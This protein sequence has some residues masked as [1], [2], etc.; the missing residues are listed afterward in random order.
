MTDKIVRYAICVYYDS[1]GELRPFMEHFLLS[2]KE[3]CTGIL[4]VINGTITEN[5]KIKISNLGI[6]ILQREN[7]GYDFHAYRDGYLFLKNTHQLI[8]DELIFCNSSCYGPVTPIQNVFEVMNRKNVDFWGLTQWHSPPWPDHIQSYFL[9]FRKSI[10]RSLDFEKYWQHLPTL[11]NRKE[12]I[13]KCEVSLTS[14][15][16]QK[17]Y[18]WETF[19]KPLKPDYSMTF[20]YEGL[21]DGLPLVKRKFF[22]LNKD[23]VEKKNVISFLMNKTEYDTRLIYE[24]FFFVSFLSEAENNRISIKDYIKSNYPRLSKVLIFIKNICEHR[25]G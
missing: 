2:L 14:H 10:Y 18:R 6:N 3:V 4:L 19:I 22:L 21:M 5:S 17:G 25:H 1:E 13:E 9:V 7:K 12:A 15:F 23:N 16:A 11:R 24:D 20:V 8:M